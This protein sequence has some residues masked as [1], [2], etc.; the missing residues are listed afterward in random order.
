[1]RKPHSSE[2]EA[3]L[4]TSLHRIRY[5]ANVLLVTGKKTT[6]RLGPVVKTDSAK[7]LH[8]AWPVSKSVP[9]TRRVAL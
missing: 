6:F 5:T 3:V 8:P 2:A 7:A 1:M 9:V 4:L